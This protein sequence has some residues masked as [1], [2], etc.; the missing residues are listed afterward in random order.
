MASSPLT[1]A[2]IEVLDE[3]LAMLGESGIWYRVTGGLA[4]NVHG[5]AWPLHDID[6][7]Y[8]RAD[9]RDLERALGKRLVTTPAKYED[10]EFR[11]VMAT[12][13][14]RSIDVEFCQIEDA[15]VAGPK[16]WVPLDAAPERRERRLWLGRDIWTMPL[17]DLIAYKSLLGRTA[18]LADLRPLASGDDVSGSSR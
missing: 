10:D 8:R 1:P 14:I 4:G 5:S 2:Q 16:G 15:F 18:D 7:D 9:W 13:R 12:A 17:A 11:L 3:L 6:I